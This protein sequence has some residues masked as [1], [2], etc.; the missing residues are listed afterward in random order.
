MRSRMTQRK[1]ED[2]SH[3]KIWTPEG[4]NPAVEPR[5]SFFVYLSSV[6]SH[7]T[8]QL[9]HPS[10]GEQLCALCPD[11]ILPTQP[12]AK[13]KDGTP[14]HAMCLEMRQRKLALLRELKFKTKACPLC[15]KSTP[16]GTVYFHEAGMTLAFACGDGMHDNPH[17][18]TLP[19]GTAE[20]RR[21]GTWEA[22]LRRR[23]KEKGYVNCCECG[24][25]VHSDQAQS[26]GSGWHYCGCLPE[27]WKAGP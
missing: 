15:G 9:S 2:L 4:L 24:R 7:L 21:V 5:G 26:L 16:L 3:P 25:L 1:G 14:A 10:E 20:T 23:L 18:F 12:S 19:I 22:R 17:L 8:R 13:S 6:L 11:P 27:L